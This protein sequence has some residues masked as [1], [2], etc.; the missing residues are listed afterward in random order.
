MF[1]ARR[2]IGWLFLLLPALTALAVVSANDSHHDDQ[3]GSLPQ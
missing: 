2:P 3:R 1:D